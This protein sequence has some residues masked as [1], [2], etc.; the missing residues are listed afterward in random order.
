ML[1]ICSVLNATI[2]KSVIQSSF[3][4]QTNL[5]FAI[6]GMSTDSTVFYFSQWQITASVT[7]NMEYSKISMQI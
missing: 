5:K 3:M 6:H 2:F 1:I 4:Y 7:N